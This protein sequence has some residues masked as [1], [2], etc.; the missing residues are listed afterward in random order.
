MRLKC[1]SAIAGDLAERERRRRKHQQRRR[2]ALRRHAGE[3]RGLDAAVGPD[4]VDQRQPG[5]DLV[6]R[7]VEHALLL[8]EGA[9]GDFGRMRVDGDGG[10]AFDRRHVAQVLAEVRLVDR[11]IVVERQQHGRNDA[12]RN[13][14]SRAA[15]FA[16][17]PSVTR[18][19]WIRA[20]GSPA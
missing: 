15:A 4:A 2:A 5:A 11:Q 6:L 19:F 8:V 16:A 3:P 7:D 14:M 13:I 18:C 20:S 10:Q 17:P 12:V 1:A 9:G